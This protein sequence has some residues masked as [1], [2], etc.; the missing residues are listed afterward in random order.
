MHIH[1]LQYVYINVC[2]YC[3]F[4]FAPIYFAVVVTT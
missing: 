2:V 4:F 1:V 3:V